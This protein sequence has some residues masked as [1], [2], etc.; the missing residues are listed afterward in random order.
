VLL[1]SGGTPAQFVG[2]DRVPDPSELGAILD[3]FVTYFSQED[4]F[5]AGEPVPLTVDGAPALA[6]DLLSRNET[7]RFAGRI[8]MAQEQIEVTKYQILQQTSFA[9][10]AQA[11]MNSQSVLALFQ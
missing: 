9:M 8:V 3:S 1:L 5:D 4:D 10:L 6:V 2:A 7:N 11:N